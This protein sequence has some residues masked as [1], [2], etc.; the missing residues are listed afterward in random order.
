MYSGLT[1]KQDR[2]LKPPT[3]LLGYCS[4]AFAVGTATKLSD[5]RC[6][7]IQSMGNLTQNLFSNTPEV[8]KRGLLYYPY[9]LPLF[10]KPLPQGKTCGKVCVG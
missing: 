10:S 1:K 2:A 6:P 7:A 3:Y 4:R 5:N 8:F 9:F